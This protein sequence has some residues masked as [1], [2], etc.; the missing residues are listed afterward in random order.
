[1]E[2]HSAIKRNEIVLFAGKWMELENTIL[3]EG[4]QVQKD[5]VRMF[6]HKC[7]INPK[8][9][10]YTNTNICIYKYIY[11]YTCTYIYITCLQ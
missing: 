2:C 6:S 9:N 1:M 3:S 8:V 11:V 4:S 5:K 7:K 10:V